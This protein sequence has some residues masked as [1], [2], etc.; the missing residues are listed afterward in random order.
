MDWSEVP[1]GI[2]GRVDVWVWHEVV[3]DH[4]AETSPE[5]PGRDANLEP[6]NVITIWQEGQGKPSEI[7]EFTQSV[8]ISHH[9]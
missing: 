9:T 2:G 5:L 7:V 3:Q 1:D 4:R 6:G 8:S